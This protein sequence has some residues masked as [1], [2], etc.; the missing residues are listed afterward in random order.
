MITDLKNWNYLVTD[1]KQKY[2][3]N[4]SDMNEINSIIK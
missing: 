4:E 1:K 2:I 3:I